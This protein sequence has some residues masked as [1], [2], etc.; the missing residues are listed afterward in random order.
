[1]AT[2]DVLDDISVWDG[3]AHS[4]GVYE[5]SGNCRRGVEK[6]GSLRRFAVN[7]GTRWGRSLVES[8]VDRKNAQSVGEK[9]RHGG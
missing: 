7:D 8:R 9:K 4:D 5:Y 1:M 3:R 2:C 6:R